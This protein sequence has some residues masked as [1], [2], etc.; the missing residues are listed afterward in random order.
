MIERQGSVRRFVSGVPLVLVVFLAWS[1][2]AHAEEEG[3]R[4]L[5]LSLETG[6]YLES[7]SERQRTE[8]GPLR[9][10]PRYDFAGPLRPDVAIGITSGADRGFAWGGSVLHRGNWVLRE[11]DG[12]GRRTYGTLVEWMGLAE[13]RI[14]PLGPVTVVAGVRGGLVTLFPGD[15][16]RDRI[17]ELEDQGSS[18]W[19]GPRLGV[20]A[21]P[22]VGARYRLAS[23]LALRADVG[24]TWSRVW[25]QRVSDTAAGVDIRRHAHVNAMRSRMALGL[26]VSF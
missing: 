7:G 26:E 24:L 21:G 2:I 18:V 11:D 19:S 20:V 10:R 25:L 16:L 13:Y 4:S 12:D 14:A 17:D 3:G 6:L 8:I 5:S 9:T 22:Q 15:D 23:R 1:G